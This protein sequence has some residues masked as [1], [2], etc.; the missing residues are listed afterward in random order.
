MD[1]DNISVKEL[2]DCCVEAHLLP[3]DNWQILEGSVISEKA[4]TR[5]E[6]GTEIIIERIP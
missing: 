5:E 6:E 4:R 2:Q 1:W 3:D